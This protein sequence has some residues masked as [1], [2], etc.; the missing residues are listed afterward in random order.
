[1]R[2][3]PA[4]NATGFCTCDRG[5]QVKDVVLDG[6]MERNRAMHG[7]TVFV[8]LLV[9]VKKEEEEGSKT[10]SCTNVE[11][12]VPEPER[13]GGDDIEEHW[14]QDDA[15]QVRLWDP[16]VPLRRSKNIP[17]EDVKRS[18]EEALGQRHGRVVHVVHPKVMANEIR[19][20]EKSNE[21]PTRRIVG[22][23]KRLKRGTS[24]LTPSNKSMEQFRLSN[25]AAEK[26]KDAPESA[27][28][29]AKYVYGSWKADCKWPPCSDVE[30]FGH[31]GNIEDE[32]AALLIENG[33]DHGEFPAAVLEESQVVVASGQYTHGSESGWKPTPDMYKGR[34]DYRKQRIFTVDPTTAKDLDD[35]LHITDLGNGQYEVGVHIADVSHF[36]QPDSHID[37]EAQLRCTTV[38]LVDRTIPMLPR[39]LCEVACS[40]NPN[41][42]R[43]AF[44]CVWKMNRD[45]SVVKDQKVWYGRT[46]IKSCAKLDYA[47]AQN[48]IEK[49]V[50]I[51]ENHVDEGLWPSSR[52][53]TGG[54]TVDQ[55]A[56]DVRLMNDIAQARRRLRFQN[57][58]IALN[59]VKLTFKLESDGE[60]PLMCEPYPIRDSNKMI[61][62]YMLMA[63]YLVAQRLIT[64]AGGRALLRNH[65]PPLEEG[66]E[67][68]AALAM[69][70]IGFRVDISSSES[71]QRSL[72]RLGRE[73]Q[74]EIILQCVTE[75]LKT[76]MKPANYIA[77]GQLDQN[78]WAHFALHIPYYTHFTSPIRRYA[79]VIVHRLLQATLDGG[80]AVD[81]FPIDDRQIKQI[82]EE[83]NEKKDGSRKAQERSDVVFLALYLRRFP[84][85]NVLGVVLSIGAKAFTVFLPSL[86]ISAMLYLEEHDDWIE[87]EGY[88]DPNFG[89]RIKLKRIKKHKVAQWKDLLVKNF[90]KVSVSCRCSEKPP[91]SVKL[92][93]EG[94]WTS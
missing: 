43:L 92:E 45:G 77:A 35:A 93:L 85:K 32:T 29:Q 64:H 66:L 73:C 84:M 58:A 22:T 59:A 21:M 4:K 7:D 62:E 3:L 26:F 25:L 76:P 2:V 78:M 41:V 33:V 51:G 42:E 13:E 72:N 9:E 18:D 52:L 34:R 48:I 75:L 94:P 87:Y 38:Y 67:K 54:H 39:A 30:Q 24:L 37:M 44:S 1:M 83:C 14:W 8:E 28:F 90:T 49:K 46:V 86:G 79:D 15:D 63:N 68:A 88:E 65:E 6:P 27:I 60:T 31:S 47:T 53:P 91:L 82:C 17:K 12:T 5:T 23:L 55:V 20:T 10:E 81:N 71:L 40:L 50:A 61:E 89:N 70:A 11:T 36:V 69:E 16:V 19:P 80:D 74:D 56:A 57:G